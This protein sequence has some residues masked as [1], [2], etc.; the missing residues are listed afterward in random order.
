MSYLVEAYDFNGDRVFGFRT[1]D[2]V[3]ALKELADLA[4]RR[5]GYLAFTHATCY[6]GQHVVWELEVK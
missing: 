6:H 1:E 4:S 3:N 2:S 5:D